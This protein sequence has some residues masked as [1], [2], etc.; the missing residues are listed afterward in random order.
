MQHRSLHIRECS[1]TGLR[2]AGVVTKKDKGASPYL[3][4]NADQK[5][6][7]RRK[8]VHILRWVVVNISTDGFVDGYLHSLQV[9]CYAQ[10]WTNG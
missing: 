4:K 1:V 6:A 8:L 7:P 9:Q 3:L 2:V 10:S 5:G